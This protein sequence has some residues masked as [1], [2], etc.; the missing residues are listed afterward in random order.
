M[1]E[2]GILRVPWDKEAAVTRYR[3]VRIECLLDISRD[4]T[5]ETG[6]LAGD[7]RGLKA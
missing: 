6:V 4:R 5:F 1:T 7:A 2:N 3:N